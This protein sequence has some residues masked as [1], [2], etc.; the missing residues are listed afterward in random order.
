MG[1]TWKSRRR[2]WGA[3]V[4]AGAV[5][6]A[7]ACGGD[8]DTQED[9][10]QDEPAAEQG[11]ADDTS[12]EP[13]HTEE[14]AAVVAVVQEFYLAIDEGDGDRACGLLVDTMQSFYAEQAAD[15]PTAIEDIHDNLGDKR[16]SIIRLDAE[17][18]VVSGDSATLSAEDIAEAN[19]TD[20]DSVDGFEFVRED[21]G[22][23]ISYVS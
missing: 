2:V 11:G 15:C 9:T 7:A 22:W 14:Q 23:L 20:R 12:P 21:D 19:D 4:A 5:S 17:D 16:M 3:I 8:E 18:V 1:E 10:Q 13:A 6:F